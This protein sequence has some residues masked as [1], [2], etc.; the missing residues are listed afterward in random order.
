MGI[1]HIAVATP[2]RKRFDYLPATGMLEHACVGMR[3][4]IPWQNKKI[5]GVIL[6]IDS[7][8]DFPLEKLKQAIKLLDDT[9]VLTPE[10]ISLAKWACDYYQHPI[11]DVVFQ[12]LPIVLR[13]DLT[14][15][16]T[17]DYRWFINPDVTPTDMG[18]AKKQAALYQHLQQLEKGVSKQY[19]IDAGFSTAIINALA[20]KHY[21]QRKTIRQHYTHQTKQAGLTLN[22]E[23][24]DALQQVTKALGEFQA[25]ILDGVTGS[26]KTEVYLQCIAKVLQQQQQVLVLVP[27]IGLTPQTLTRFSQ[28]FD[29]RI[30]VMHSNLTDKQRY[31]NWRAAK[32]GDARLVIGTRSAIFA[33]FEHL[34]L[35]IID[36]SHDASFKQQDSFRYSAR[37]LAMVRAKRLNIPILMGSATPAFETLANVQRNKYHHLRLRQRA[38]HAKAPSYEL[39]DIRRQALYAGLAPKVIDAIK[40][41]IA[42][43]AQVLLF[44]N[45][46]GFAPTLMC[47]EC[48]WLAECKHCDA[49]MTLHLSPRHLHCHHCDRARNVPQQCPKCQGDNV[50]PLGLGTERI[51]HHLESLFPGTGICRIDRDTT[52]RKGAL[53]ELL[54]TIH[55]GQQQLLLG[56]QMIAKGHH[57]PKVTLVVVINADSGFFSADFRSGERMAQLLIQVAGRAGRAEHPG[58]VMIQT[59]NPEHPSLQLLLSGGYLGFAKEELQLRQ[60]AALPPFAFQ[61]LLRADSHKPDVAEHF[62]RQLKNLDSEDKVHVLGPIPAP[63]SKRA[64]RHR[65]QLLLQSTNRKKL[66]DHLLQVV[67]K[68]DGIKKEY[69]IRW[70]VDVDP[71][72]TY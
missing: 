48:G 52:R 8:S 30:V 3:V 71:I 58:H 29:T 53:N 5:V 66:H 60:S 36:E 44:L 72:D 57:F 40:Q 68:I 12:M 31:L 2:L 41:H 61:A 59:R 11:G 17:Q 64:G 34:G 45:R 19:L 65:A 38:G 63:M 50:I 46:R 9:P 47:H 6:A 15:P 54:E 67:K 35:I 22:Q 14:L 24:S 39:I 51:E 16:D 69:S 28:R 21:I 23:Q 1:L 33:P 18:R 42:A 55:S 32:N 62:L 4:L 27:E 7:H 13:K 37:D 49:R 70:S 26:G 25:F 10:L 20:Q 43:K 56:T